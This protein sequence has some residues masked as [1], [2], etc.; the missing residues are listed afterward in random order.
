MQTIDINSLS[1][2]E[3]KAAFKAAYDSFP[4]PLQV[5]PRT[6]AVA[7]VVNCYVRGKHWRSHAYSAGFLYVVFRGSIAFVYSL[8]PLGATYYN[9]STFC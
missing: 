5:M 7:K 1:E 4:S 8:Q 3:I 6:P 2:S 9:L